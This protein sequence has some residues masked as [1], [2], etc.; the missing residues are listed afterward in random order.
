[1]KV[2]LFAFIPAVLLLLCG[3]GNALRLDFDDVHTIEIMTADTRVSVTDADMVERITD[4]IDG[5]DY[6]LVE[7]SR[8]E[9]ELGYVYDTCYTLTWYNTDGVAIESVEIAEENGHQIA[10]DAI[11]YTVDAD[12]SVDV[13]MLAAL[14]LGE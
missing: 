12:L 14:V 4:H 13:D 1:M 11:V 6:E 2:R 9:A 7:L 3:C 5:L 10:H 8:E